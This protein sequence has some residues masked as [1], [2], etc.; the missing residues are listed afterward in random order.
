MSRNIQQELREEADA[1]GMKLSKLKGF[2]EKRKPADMISDHWKLLH[3]QQKAMQKYYNI[4]VLR[5][6]NLRFD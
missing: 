2:L 6:D 3:K 5:I 4:L 1:L